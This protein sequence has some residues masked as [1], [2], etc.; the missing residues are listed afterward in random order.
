MIRKE[1][2]IMK[3]LV[4]MALCFA[5]VLSLTPMPAQVEAAVSYV[6][7][8]EDRIVFGE[9]NRLGLY[10]DKEQGLVP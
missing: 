2:N 1:Y 10:L 7:N 3:K 6:I 5:M 8:D 4:A 9:E